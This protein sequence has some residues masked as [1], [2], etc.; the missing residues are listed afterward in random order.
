M[1]IDSS[2]LLIYFSLI[3]LLSSIVELLNLFTPFD[4][5]IFCL[6]F[7]PTLIFCSI[8]YLIINLHTPEIHIFISTQNLEEIQSEEKPNIDMSIVA[9]ILDNNL[10]TNLDTNLSTNLDTNI[11]TNEDREASP[12]PS[13]I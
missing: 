3:P 12:E 2:H 9:E 8:F 6:I 4:Y 11:D 7:F 10:S 5:I 1:F 13:I